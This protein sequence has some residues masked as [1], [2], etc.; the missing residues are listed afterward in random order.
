MDFLDFTGGVKPYLLDRMDNNIGAVT[1]VTYSSFT[2]FYLEDQ[3]K[4]ET[5]WKTP[6]PFPVQVVS[7]VILIDELSR[8]KLTT[9]YRYHHGYWDGVEREFRGFGMVEQFDSESFTGPPSLLHFSPP[10]CTKTWF[11]HGAVGD[12]TDFAEL[13]LGTEFWSGD[14]GLLDHKQ[15]IDAFLRTQDNRR[16]RRDAL[17]ALRGSILRTELYALDGTERADRPYTV[18]ER[19]YG[20]RR[21]AVTANGDGCAVFFPHR[22]A[23]RTTQWERGDDPLTKFAFTETQDYDEFGQVLRST[24]I[25][26]PRGWRTLNDAP[27]AAYLATRTL[28]AYAKPVDTDVIYIVDRAARSTSYE[29]S[30]SG[31]V[32]LDQLH[33]L[34]DD[35]ASLS[36]IGQTY[37]YYDGPAFQG[38]ASGQIGSFGAPTRSESLVLT[39]QILHEAYKRGGTVLNPPEEPPY[40]TLASTV[41]WT[42]DYP[43]DFRTQLPALG[44]YVFHPGGPDARDARGYFARTDARRYDFQAGS[45]GRGLI[46]DRLDPLGHDTKIIYDDFDLLPVKVIDPAE[47]TTEAIY[48]YRVLQP[49]QVT[50]NNGNQSLFSFTPLGLLSETFIRGKAG[51][52][53]GDQQQPSVRLIYDFLAFVNSKLFNPANPQPILVHTTRR[54]HHDGESDVPLPE[55]DDIIESREYSDGFGRLLQTRTQAEDTLFGDPIFGDKVLP[56]DQSD[57]AGTN[58]DVIGRV[59]GPADPPNVVVSG[60]QLYDNKGRVVEKYEPFFSQGF[61]YAAPTDQ[62]LGQ[63]VEIFYDPRGQVIRSVNPD[64]SEQRVIFGVPG[65]IG[66]PDLGSPT[67]FEPTPWEAYTYDPNDNAGRT[68][69]ATSTAFRHHWDTPASIVIDALGR[70]VVS[71]TRN[72]DPS[73]NPNDPPPPIEEISTLS[74]YDIRGNLLTVTDPLG[75]QAFSHVYDHANRPLRI[76][77]IDAGLRRSVLDAAGNLI[78]RRDSKG[79]WF[80]THTISS[81]A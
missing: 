37:N 65:T 61:D 42:P 12:D 60:W 48:D 58:A 51:E 40:L 6:L 43:V 27:K 78:E 14:A 34:P 79:A 8:G 47:L 26:C 30:N 13:D 23:Q 1:S 55:R 54:C 44:G 36:L 21:E 16:M 50:D 66:A 45:P 22:V 2:K 72:R 64:L 53:V 56:A 63:K 70:T 31:Q 32:T 4:P 67:K 17:R 71:V 41:P 76:E 62:Q 49:K 75:R 29:L 57:V 10:T 15:A 5:R 38:F 25:A 39:E 7:K 35:S 28:T 3:K 80:S 11:H 46:F 73:Q 24:E 77:S 52:A 68:H 9:E 19:A 20:L 18:T 69:P 74:A 59:R 33:Q 81:I